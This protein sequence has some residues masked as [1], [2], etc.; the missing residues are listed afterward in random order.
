MGT[1]AEVLEMTQVTG[2]GILA[3]APSSDSIR[4][5]LQRILVSKTFQRAKRLRSLLDY[6]VCG[7][8]HGQVGGQSKTAR[9]LFGKSDDFDPS[10]DPVIR[11]QFGRLRRALTAYYA[12]EGHSDP[13]I[14]DIP[15]RRYT[16]VFRNSL[17]AVNGHTPRTDSDSD[18]LV[19]N[20]GRDCGTLN[21]TGR[22]LIAVLPFANLT[23][24]PTNDMFCYGLTEEIAHGLA[25]VPSVDVVATSSSFQ[26]RDE[27]VDVREAGKELGVPLILEGSVRMEEGHT[28]VIAQLARSTDGVAVWSD[29]F[30]DE[31]NGSLNTQKNIAQKVMENLPLGSYEA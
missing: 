17:A 19:A 28:R 21:S 9:E 30:D 13:V 18:S 16:P 31:M 25:S 12:A 23:S 14:I 8:I 4:E 24:D 20:E 3:F 7:A 22:Q 5:Q 27:H 29:S 11:V 15:N 1:M 2:N 10:L 6:V 26:F